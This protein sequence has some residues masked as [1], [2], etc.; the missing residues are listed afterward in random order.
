[1]QLQGLI[2]GILRYIEDHHSNVLKVANLKL[3]KKTGLNR[4]SI[5]RHDFNDERCSA[6]PTELSSQ[7]EAGSCEFEATYGG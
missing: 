2:F 3:K 1:M 4:I 5:L 7:L 6:Q